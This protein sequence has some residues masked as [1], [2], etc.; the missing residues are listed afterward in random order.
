MPRPSY[1]LP[2]FLLAAQLLPLGLLAQQNELRSLAAELAPDIVAAGKKTIA[3][4]DFTDLQGNSS[5][6]GRFLAEEFS[7]ALLR[8]RKGFDVV[9]RNHLKAIL[10]EH[11]L[12]AS[13]VIDPATAQNIG[14]FTGADA[15]VTGS[16][17][18]FSESVRVA[19]KILATDT[20]R[21]VA[22]DTVDLAK[23]Q[24]IADLLGNSSGAAG[25]PGNR[26]NDRPPSATPPSGQ[27]EGAGGYPSTTQAASAPSSPVVVVGQFQ[28]QLQECRGTANSVRCSFRITNLGQDRTLM[29]WCGNFSSNKTK[30]F[31]NI[32]NESPGVECTIANKT[33]M[34]MVTDTVEAQLITGVTV[35]AIIIFPNVSAAATSLALINIF[36]HWGQPSYGD[37]N[38]SFRNV[39]IVR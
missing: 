3:V 4:V 25:R 39:P 24:T 1:L 12:T 6:L 20:A 22:A 17:T 27:R 5:D 11:K 33:S 18:P 31:D 30:A 21:I 37:G 32:G 8:T 9:E 29:H 15:I 19:V 34:M 16:M 14:K 28:Y 35:P 38:V 2:S 7:V 13:G 10:S 36:A 23:T 26:V